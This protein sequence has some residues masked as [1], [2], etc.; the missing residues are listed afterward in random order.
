LVG[1]WNCESQQPSSAV[2]RYDPRAG[3]WTTMAPM[4]TPRAHHGVIELRGCLYVVG[5]F[6]S[7]SKREV[8]KYDPVENSWCQVAPL[9]SARN[10][11][12]CC[13]VGEYIYVVGG[14]EDSLEGEDVVGTCERYDPSADTWC[15]LA[16]LPTP[17]ANAAMCEMQGC[18]YVA[19]GHPTDEEDTLQVVEKFDPESGVWTT[20]SRLLVARDNFS[21]SCYDGSLF[22]RS[23]HDPMGGGDASVERYDPVADLWTPGAP[24]LSSFT[25]IQA[26]TVSTCVDSIDCLLELAGQATSKTSVTSGELRKRRRQ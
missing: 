15:L 26:I 6:H 21:L 16:P 24:L 22:A 2:E 1:G 3:V 10:C 17:R 8:E 4:L 25:A 9:S 5:G 20:I 19:G 13:V 12:C 14:S 7:G 18:L 23:G 11:C